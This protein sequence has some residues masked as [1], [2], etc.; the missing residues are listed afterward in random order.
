MDW[1]LA[2]RVAVML[3]VERTRAVL[4]REVE[5]AL[6][7]A[8]RRRGLLHRASLDPASALVLAPCRAIHTAFMRFP[9]DVV[10]V[11]RAGIVRHICRRV[12][13]WRIAA[14]PRAYAAIEL[15]AGTLDA[16]DLARGDRL[17]F[18]AAIS[19]DLSA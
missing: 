1:G 13:P 12:P 15:A 2:R 18:G 4:A 14:A 16:H 5:L 7:R 17:C 3:T 10:F 8:A 6:T 11:D 19:L 9:I